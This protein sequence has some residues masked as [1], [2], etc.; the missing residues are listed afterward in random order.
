ML[1]SHL[2]LSAIDTWVVVVITLFPA[3][4]AGAAAGYFVYRAVLKK[5]QS[6]ADTEFA[7]VIEEARLEAKTLRK[8]ALLEAK[9]EQIRLRN[10][11]E[12]ESKDRRS[13]PEGGFHQQ[14]GGRARQETR[15]RG[16]YPQRT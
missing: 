2:M 4:I 3:L 14:K 5:K 15:E 10:E 11:F 13:E 8:D 16:A 6:D 1:G 9:E 7:R 12:K